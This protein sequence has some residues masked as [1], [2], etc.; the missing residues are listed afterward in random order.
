MMKFRYKT[1][2]KVLKIILKCDFEYPQFTGKKPFISV[3]YR[4]IRNIGHF[5]NKARGYYGT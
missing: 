5:I 2:Q 4:P 1:N 3:S